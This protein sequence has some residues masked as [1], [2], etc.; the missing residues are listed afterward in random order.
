M[1]LNILLLAALLQVPGISAQ[2]F[3][4]AIDAY[5]KLSSFHQLL[6]AN[7][8]LAGGLLSNGSIS[9]ANGTNSTLHTILVPSNDAFTNYQKAYG[10]PIDRL[11]SSDLGNVIQYHSLQGALSSS[12]LQRPRGLVANTALTAPTYDNR[13][14]GSNGA[15][16]PQVVY[17]APPSTNGTVV[18]RQIRGTNAADR[19][20]KSGLG[21]T[22]NV[23]F[24]NGRFD[25]GV[26]QIVDG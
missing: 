24:V 12:D 11:S 17:I 9:A 2:S 16:L 5:P 3:L 8:T 22:V 15:Q 20:V 13:E 23:D 26:F 21:S 25:G 18:V 4:Q 6:L 1:K 19:L 14:L 10:H 7:S